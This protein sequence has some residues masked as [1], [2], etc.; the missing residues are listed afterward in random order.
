MAASALLLALALTTADIV[1]MDVHVR[2]WPPTITLGPA[3]PISIRI[4]KGQC[5]IMEGF[6][7]TEPP[8]PAARIAPDGHT[9]MLCATREPT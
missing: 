9:L 6:N 5:A 8:S 3:G 7:I 2:D 1:A 4:A